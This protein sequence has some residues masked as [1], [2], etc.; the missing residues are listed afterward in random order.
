LASTIVF[1][2]TVSGTPRFSEPDCSV[3]PVRTF[4]H[5]TFNA[6]FTG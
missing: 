6:H 3:L 5:H 2:I 4:I 1:H